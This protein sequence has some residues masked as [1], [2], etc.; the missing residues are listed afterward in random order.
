MPVAHWDNIIITYSA[1]YLTVNAYV[2]GAL[3][4]ST[5]ALSDSNSANSLYIGQG[6]GGYMDGDIANV[7]IY[8]TSLSTNEIQYLYTEGIGGAPL[9]LQNLVGWWPLNGNA[10]DYSGDNN[11]GAPSGVTYTSQWTSGYT[12][13]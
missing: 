9:K 1:A 11:N 6:Y 13:P 7:Q 4:S 12:P 5:S 2:N 3:Q 8:N 10:N